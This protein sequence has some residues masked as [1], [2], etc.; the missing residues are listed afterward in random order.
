MPQATP[1]LGGMPPN[2]GFTP[3][4]KLILPIMV[5]KFVPF[6]LKCVLAESEISTESERIFDSRALVCGGPSEHCRCGTAAL[7]RP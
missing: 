7:P 4:P 5:V 1:D 2:M 3:G 6:R